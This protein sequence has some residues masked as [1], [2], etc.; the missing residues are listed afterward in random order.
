MWLRCGQEIYIGT[1]YG[2]IANH[3]IEILANTAGQAYVSAYL[4]C[5][6]NENPR[7]RL[8]RFYRV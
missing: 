6:I 5:L 2:I 7:N 1:G 3:N 8:G 4:G